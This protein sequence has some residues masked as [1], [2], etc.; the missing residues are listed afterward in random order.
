VR[1]AWMIG[2]SP[3]LLL[4]AVALAHAQDVPVLDVEPVCRGIAQQ[5][6]GAGERGGPDL[7]LSQCIKSE[8]AM[9]ERLVKEWSTF[10]P[11]DKA[12]CV[13]EEKSG[14]LPSYTDLVSCLEMARD[15]RK[16]DTGK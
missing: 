10:A 1:R 8:Q 6:S 11:A 3:A 12:N 14:P 2:T 15:A 13:G 7:G 16:L 4:I 5:A 9:R